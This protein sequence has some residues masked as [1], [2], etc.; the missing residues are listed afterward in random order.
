MHRR[1]FMA[2]A[3]ALAFLFV[4]HADADTGSSRIIRGAVT[5]SLL[6]YYTAQI[7]EPFLTAWEAPSVT[8][9]FTNTVVCADADAYQAA[10]FAA[11]DATGDFSLRWD[12]Q[13]DWD[14]VSTLSAGVTSNIQI[15]G[16][17][18]DTLS[19]RGRG[20]CVLVRPA[21]G[22]T[23]VLGNTMYI[24]SI[25]GIEFQD[26]GFGRKYTGVGTQQN[27]YGVHIQYGAPTRPARP[28]VYFTNCNF[29]APAC[30]LTGGASEWCAP[31]FTTGVC[32]M[33]M[34]DRCNMHGAATNIINMRSKHVLIKE[35]DVQLSAE[36][37]A[38][39]TN[40]QETGYQSYIWYDRVTARNP[41]DTTL[42]EAVHGD[43]GQFGHAN[44]QHI[45]YRVLVTNS[46]VSL[47]H[48]LLSVGG[49]GGTQGF[50][51]DD[52]TTANNQAII[53]DSFIFSSAPNG[54]NIQ[55]PNSTLPSYVDH[56]TINRAGQV[57]STQDF[58]MGINGAPLSM[59]NG[60]KVYVTN[61]IT[62]FT[63]SQPYMELDNVIICQAK[64]TA[65]V[66]LGERPETV[67]KG[68][69][70]GGFVR[71]SGKL[72]WNCPGETNGQTETVSSLTR[73]QFAAEIWAFWEPQAAFASAGAPDPRPYIL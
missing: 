58:N 55:S 13:L 44:D 4:G 52:F 40:H 57:P 9:S 11:C 2:G 18:S 60:Q 5:T 42:N 59:G 71:T 25:D 14:G 3:C 50:Y 10:M 72:S 69:G 64:N 30:G 26:I 16:L 67:F 66:P 39:W 68:L 62:G 8:N 73:A 41:L 32:Q 12:I 56:C 36:D 7:K 46:I 19:Y 54:Y 37:V 21:T 38:N 48:T 28:Y 49:E 23:P 63:P 70:T 33:V 6:E 24:L 20:G 27:T 35:T 1:G 22:R 53:R 45:G 61:T 31:I 15:D 17:G 65:S 47:N 43:G 34:F 29:G 51:F